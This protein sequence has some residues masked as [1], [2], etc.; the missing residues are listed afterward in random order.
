MHGHLNVK[1]LQHLTFT[2][3][4]NVALTDR[5]QGD[6]VLLREDQ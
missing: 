3:V 5:K 6:K 4:L 2:V 1:C